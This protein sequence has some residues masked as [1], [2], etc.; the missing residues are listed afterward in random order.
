MIEQS[1]TLNLRELDPHEFGALTESH[2]R[3]LRAHCYRMLGS[4]QEA[5]EIVQETFLRA[6]NRRKT[7]E[8]Q[9]GR[10]HV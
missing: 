9:I 7:Y 8:G 1:P 3:E 6:W 10:A 4:I 2:R 5:D